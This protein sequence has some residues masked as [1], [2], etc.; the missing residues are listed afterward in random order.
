MDRVPGGRP[1]DHGDEAD[2]RRGDLV[3]VAAFDRFE[4]STLERLDL[5][6]VAQVLEPLTCSGADALCLLLGVGHRR[7]R[8]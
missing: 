5:G 1:I 6:A 3:A 4:Q 8:W 2:V 7:G